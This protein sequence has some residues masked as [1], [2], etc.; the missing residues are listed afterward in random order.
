[1]KT[2]EFTDRLTDSFS[3][4]RRR[5]LS[6]LALSLSTTL[7]FGALGAEPESSWSAL[8]SGTIVLFRHAIAPG[9]GD[10]ANFK[11]GDCSTQRNLDAS[12]QAQA[13]RIGEQFRA[14]QVS[15]QK[16]LTSQWCRAQETA[17]LAFPD[18]VQESPVFNSFFGKANRNSAQSEQ[19]AAALE[20]FRQ[21]KGPGVLAVVT[22]QVNITALTGIYPASGEGVIV[23]TQ[24]GALV[25]LGRVQP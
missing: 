11:R 6:V 21:W 7:S 14:Q 19:T 15:V 23:Q 5:M 9:T 3:Q 12:G 25:V 20:I 24:A 18:R 16:V 1:M 2:T 4:G 8:Q 10:P 13:R 17:Q 22:H